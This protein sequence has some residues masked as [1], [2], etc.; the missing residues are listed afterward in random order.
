LARAQAEL[1]IAALRRLV[2]GVTC[3]LVAVTT[4]GDRDTSTPLPEIGGKG[5]F[6]QELEERL[7]RCE[8]AVAVHSLKDL[9]TE[10][11]PDLA[12]AAVLERADAADVLV[13]RSG[14]R[15]A[16]LP[17]SPGVGTSS[18][19]REAQ[20]LEL[21]PDARLVPLRG[22]VDTRI[23]KASE[24][25]G[26]YDAVVIAAA[27]LERL[28]LSA[29]TVERF[30]PERFLPA[31][32]QGAIAVQARTHD[33]LLPLLAR[34]D[35]APT[36]AAVTAERAFLAALD[37]GCSAPVGAYG[38][39]VEGRLVV[40]GLVATRDARVVVRVKVEGAPEFAEALGVELAERARRVGATDVLREEGRS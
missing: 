5:V 17:G 36:R 7:R 33:P 21:R 34:L 14:L 19:R 15:L 9:P 20:V 22:N 28:G 23:R 12:I 11:P 13:S 3:E 26:P 4:R 24:A 8:I 39:V 31:P 29:R 10:S 2:P 18:L 37:A 16:D 27:G 6:T 30:P 35:H 25:E 40:D 38:R 1:V 32:G